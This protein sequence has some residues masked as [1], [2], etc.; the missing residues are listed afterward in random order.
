MDNFRNNIRI[1]IRDVFAATKISILVIISVKVAFSILNEE[2]I[3]ENVMLDF[4]TYI[5]GTT[6]A[7]EIMGARFESVGLLSFNII[8]LFALLFFSAFYDET[9]TNISNF[10]LFILIAI[11]GFIGALTVSNRI[12]FCTPQ[13]MVV[14]FI[15]FIVFKVLSTFKLSDK[16]PIITRV[17]II[18]HSLFVIVVTIIPYFN[19]DFYLPFFE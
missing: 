6:F 9:K 7:T 8:L 2:E 18:A 19:E 14:S 3:F 11:V 1:M 5:L 4:R 16:L 15:I 10:I 13:A 17:V 12:F